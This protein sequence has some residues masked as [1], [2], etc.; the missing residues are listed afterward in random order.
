MVTASLL[1]DAVPNAYYLRGTNIGNVPPDP[2]YRQWVAGVLAATTGAPGE[3]TKVDYPGGFWPVS[4]GYL[5][6]PTWNTSIHQ[7]ATDLAQAIAAG[8]D[9][10]SA[11]IIVGHSQ[12]AV[13]VTEYLRAHPT[14]GNVYVLTG[15]PNRPNGGVLQ[16]FNG[17]Y[18]PI[19]DISFNGATPTDGDTVIDTA[20]QYDG[21][22]DFPKYPLNLLATAN[23]LLGIVYLHGKYDQA[24]TAEVL[25]GLEP[26]VHGN[27]TYYLVPT[28]RLP[29]L[30]PFTGIVPDQ[31]LDALDP[32]LRHVIETSYDRS[33][34]GQPSTVGLIP[35]INPTPSSTEL[36]GEIIDG[37]SGT[38]AASS[39][40]EPEAGSELNAAR[41]PAEVTP[42]EAEDEVASESEVG[43]ESR[44]RAR[45]SFFERWRTRHREA[46]ATPSTPSPDASTASSAGQ[47][48]THESETLPHNSSDAQ[49]QPAD[50]ASTRQ[51]TDAA[52]AD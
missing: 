9:T 2:A 49:S 45:T 29:L 18:I 40:P 6:D 8:G 5:S 34:Y 4:K 23:A 21:W 27:T 50:S 41:G 11:V 51:D 28:E 46:S 14:D 15:N 1:A 30:M 16:R 17:L 12:G 52:A 24:V 37:R 3:L 22:A 33:D 10:G 48:E 35:P 20:R 44:S 13:A 38:P 47:S 31:I 32:P 26:T 42:T 25:A 36:G 19:L 7:G 43:G 39:E